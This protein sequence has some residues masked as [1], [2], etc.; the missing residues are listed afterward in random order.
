[1]KSIERMAHSTIW[2]AALTE[3]PPGSSKK[4]YIVWRDQLVEGFV[5]NLDSSYY[6]YVNYCAHAGTPLDWWPN[7][8]FDKDRQLLMCGTHGSLYQPETGK[9]VGGPCTGRGLFPLQVEV[10]ADHI[11]VRSSCHA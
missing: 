8:F 5:V 1:M 11:V 3:I 4:F 2:T 10:T 6:A 9:C 7:E